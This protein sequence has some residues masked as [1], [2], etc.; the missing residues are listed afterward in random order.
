MHMDLVQYSVIVFPS[1][2]IV[3]LPSSKI[4]YAAIVTCCLKY[5][6]VS[7]DLARS[8]TVYVTRRK[9]G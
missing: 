3:G 5:V 6:G 2:R 4:V 9:S 8:Q 7:Q 1:Q